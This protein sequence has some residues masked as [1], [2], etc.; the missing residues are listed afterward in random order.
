MGITNTRQLGAVV[1][2]N[3]ENDTQAIQV[4]SIHMCQDEYLKGKLKAKENN[5]LH[6]GIN[7]QEPIFEACKIYADRL[8]F[9]VLGQ[10]PYP[11]PPL[12]AYLEFSLFIDDRFLAPIPANW[13][14]TAYEDVFRRFEQERNTTFVRVEDPIR[15]IGPQ[16]DSNPPARATEDSSG[17]I[18]RDGPEVLGP[19]RPVPAHI[20]ASKDFDRGSDGETREGN[21]SV[22][23]NRR[24][25]RSRRAINY[26]GQNFDRK[27]NN[28]QQHKI[29]CGHIPMAVVGSRIPP[30]HPNIFKHPS[31]ADDA[32]MSF[33]EGAMDSIKLREIVI[34]NGGVGIQKEESDDF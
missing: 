19:L 1:G 23:E 10:G 14:G 4:S 7:L 17:R 13:N 5:M 2:N 18:F 28:R 9:H 30:R 25:R 12:P 22:R 29:N 33:I 27:K 31:L 16:R 6:F 32:L 26:R 15:F 20:N 21:A 11:G 24:R 3:Y 8:I 34:Q